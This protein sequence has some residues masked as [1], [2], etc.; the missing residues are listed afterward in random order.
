M[1]TSDKKEWK[2]SIKCPVDGRELQ[3]LSPP[4]ESVLSS[5]PNLTSVRLR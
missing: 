5:S 4:E 1:V 3:P 2:K